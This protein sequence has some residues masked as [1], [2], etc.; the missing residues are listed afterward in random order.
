M[1]HFTCISVPLCARYSPSPP[2]YL[3]FDLCTVLLSQELTTVDSITGLP[4]SLAPSWLWSVGGT[5]GSLG[6][7]SRGP[8]SVVTRLNCGKPFN[9]LAL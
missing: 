6:L 1:Q 9:P 8:S 5:R 7:P 3:F 2:S 4:A